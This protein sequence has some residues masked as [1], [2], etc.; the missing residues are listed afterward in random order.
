MIANMRI[1]QGTLKKINFRVHKD[2]VQFYLM[3]HFQTSSTSWQN[4]PGFYFPKEDKKA[5]K[6]KINDILGINKFNVD[7]LGFDCHFI[8]ARGMIWGVV[9]PSG[10]ILSIPSI[11]WSEEKSTIVGSLSAEIKKEFPKFEADYPNMISLSHE[12]KINAIVAIYILNSDEANNHVLS[13][14]QKY[15]KSIL[16][17][18][19]LEDDLQEKTS[20]E[21]TIKI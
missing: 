11:Y 14:V 15:Y 5:I 13:L 2:R 19:Y 8:T 12:D 21:K 16:L 1:E 17:K 6:T 9:S 20:I 7:N 3:L 18:I 4:S 10:K